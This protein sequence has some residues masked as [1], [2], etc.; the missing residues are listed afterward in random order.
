MT[1][2][3]LAFLI[4]TSV[5]S[6]LVLS[7]SPAQSQ[8]TD[9]LAQP[10]DLKLYVSPIKEYDVQPS[11]AAPAETAMRG[12]D[13]SNVFTGVLTMD[14]PLTA[15]KNEKIAYAPP[16]TDVASQ[17]GT[18]YVA[19]QPAE[20]AVQEKYEVA[21]QQT[22]EKG[23][24]KETPRVRV[25][26]EKPKETPPPAEEDPCASYTDDDYT[27]CKAYLHPDPSIQTGVNP[28]ETSMNEELFN[29]CRE[30]THN[31]FEAINESGGAYPQGPD[32]TACH[33]DQAPEDYGCFH[34]VSEQQVTDRD[35]CMKSVLSTA[36]SPTTASCT[37]D[38]TSGTATLTVQPP[39]GTTTANIKLCGGGCKTPTSPVGQKTYCSVDNLG[40]F[41]TL[42]CFHPDQI[43]SIGKIANVENRAN[44]ANVATP[45]EATSYRITFPLSSGECSQVGGTTDS[46]SKD[47]KEVEKC[48]IERPVCGCEKTPPPPVIDT[49]TTTTPKPPEQPPA[50]PQDQPVSNPD[51]KTGDGAPQDT[52][53]AAPVVQ[54]PAVLADLYYCKEGK[55]E[56]YSVVDHHR[57]KMAAGQVCPRVSDVQAI[58]KEMWSLAVNVAAAERDSSKLPELRASYIANLNQQDGIGTVYAAHCGKDDGTATLDHP[59]DRSVL[60][61]HL[62]NQRDVVI[63]SDGHINVGSNEG[64]KVFA[65]PPVTMPPVA[66]PGTSGTGG[67]T[68]NSGASSATPPTHATLTGQEALVVTNATIV[69]GTKLAQVEATT[70]VTF[71]LPV[72]SAEITGGGSCSLTR[73]GPGLQ[74]LE[75]YRQAY[76]TLALALLTLGLWRS[77]L[78]RPK[79]STTSSR[80][81]PERDS[82]TKN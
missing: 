59:V 11:P 19:E 21:V 7:S 12:G 48:V 72:A 71:A 60:F 37:S 70:A 57:V 75:T 1:E 80:N 28:A 9:S 74:G 4:R 42:P 6:L 51:R 68:G 67:S 61:D 16:K 23:E 47:K 36:K 69:D 54:Q 33:C 78:R 29:C 34:C 77:Q 79:A 49:P 14:T 32:R 2:K 55:D 31:I 52:K 22:R 38:E 15:I 64:Y 50:K 10:Q 73:T 18:V 76:W 40:K 65:A 8:T 30:K 20:K 26:K 39:Y 46:S 45:Q 3:S 66:P 63:T 17:E 13:N 44:G 35:S 24:T 53:P 27:C 5:V 56:F 25:A 58:T 41:Y 82:S 43:D 81:M 62:N